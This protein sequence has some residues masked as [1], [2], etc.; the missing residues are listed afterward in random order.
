LEPIR[1]G[2]G[3]PTHLVSVLVVNWNTCAL[4]T[5]CI[6][7]LS[8]QEAPALRFETVVV[9][10]GSADGSRPLLQE[11][12]DITFIA[13]TANLGYAAAVNQAFERSSGDLVLLLNSDVELPPAA[14]ADLV[15][16]LDEHPHAA[17]VAPLYLNP[18]GSPQ[19]FHFRFPSFAT[20]LANVSWVF[21]QLPGAAKRA[22]A[23]RMLDDDFSAPRPVDQPSAS[24]LLLRRTCLP[25]DRVFDERYPIFFNDVA[26]AQ[27][28]ARQGD[29]L[30][31]TP[32]VSVIHEGHASTRQLG[33]ALKRQYIASLVTMLGD[34]QPAWKQIVFKAVVLCQG[35]ALRGIRR[36]GALSVPDLLGAVRGDPGRLPSA[37]YTA[38]GAG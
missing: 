25:N 30:W 31:V 34:T 4:T 14:L 28:L 1:S 35:L 33:P 26:L 38:S 24:C 5:A 36:R 23:Y 10:N 17:G 29:R 2:A 9:D 20:L 22:R 21:G 11:R 19:S 12:S 32:A 6:D 3:L 18:D 27:R 7:S 16:F 13:N 8:A 15:A 37:P